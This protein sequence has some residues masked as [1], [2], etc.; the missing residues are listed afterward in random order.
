M[1]NAAKGDMQTCCM[2]Q[3]VV[4]MTAKGSRDIPQKTVLLEIQDVKIRASNNQEQT[5]ILFFDP[6][7]TLS[8]VTHK[9]ASQNVVSCC[10]CTVF[11]KV[12]NHGCEKIRTK[13]Y[14][15]KLCFENG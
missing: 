7:A 8:L 5:A 11:L 14:Q 2:T 15:L 9:F 4:V 13:E 1:V 10:P 12:V 3:E 6:G